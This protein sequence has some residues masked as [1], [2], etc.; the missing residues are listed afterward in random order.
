MSRKYFYTIVIAFFILLSSLVS[1]VVAYC[2][3]TDETDDLCFGAYK[4]CNCDTGKEQM[5]CTSAAQIR[6][7]NN[8]CSSSSGP[9]SCTYTAVGGYC[10][11]IS[12]SCSCAPSCNDCTPPACPAGSAETP[13]T[14]DAYKFTTTCSRGSGC[15]PANNTRTCYWQRQNLCSSATGTPTYLKPGQSSTVTST[16]N[17]SVNTFFY[18]FYNRDNPSLT[19]IVCSAT[20]IAG[21]ATTQGNCAPGTYQLMR[22]NTYTTARTSETISFP[23]NSIFVNDTNYG[24]TLAKNLQ[25]NAYYIIDG[26]PISFPNISCV[27]NQILCSPLCTPASCAPAY[28]T[29]NQGYGSTVFSC[30]NPQSECG[31][32]SRTCFCRACTPP[33]CEPQFSSVNYGY[34][35]TVLS[36][37][38]N[39]G[40]SGS[41]TCYIDRCNNCTLPDCPSPLTPVPTTTNPNMEL[42]VFRQCTKNPPCGGSSRV[43]SCFEQVSPQP[44]T[45]LQVFPDTTNSY[46]F[47]SNN[48][49]GIRMPNYNLNDPLHMT[50]TYTDVNGASDIEAVS[51][52]FRDSTQTGE[53]ASPLWIDSTEPP[54]AQSSSSWGFMMRY[55]G[56]SWV[57]Y[58]PSYPAIG[59][60]YWVRAVSSSGGFDIA[61]PG[62][63][64]MVRVTLGN[65]NL[66]GITRSGNNVV[67]PFQ[68]S[69]T[70]TG[71]SESV[72]QTN[73]NV[74]LMGND[75][76]SF[77]PNDNYTSSPE[78]NSKIGTYWQPG[79]LR[80]RTSPTPAQTYARQWVQRGT[81]TIDKQNP[82]SNPLSV[83]IVDD[84]VLELAWN[85]TDDKGIYA[86]VGN[87]YA[88][89]SMTSPSP[90]NIS[91]VT[92][93][94]LDVAGTYPLEQPP[95]TGIGHLN[96]NYAFRKLS[97]GSNTYSDRVRID[98]GN[99]NGGSLIIYLTVFDMA[100]N[101]TSPTLT[102]SLGDWI[103][104]YGGFTYSSGGMDYEIK[105]IEGDPW[106]A[107]D[108]LTNLDPSYADVTTELF[109]DRVASVAPSAL[110]KS[111]LV[112]SYHVRPFVANGDISNWYVELIKAYRGRL[113]ADKVDMLSISSITGNLTSSGG[114][115]TSASVCISQ[116]DNFTVGSPTQPFTCNTKGVFF[117]NG[118]LTIENEI[119]N[120]NINSDACI[121]V[122][123]GNVQINEG[124]Q[125]SSTTQIQYDRINAYIIANGTLTIAPELGDRK[126]D[127][128]FI[129]GGFYANGGLNMNRSLKLVDRNIYPAL[130]TSYHSKYAILSNLVFGSQIDMVKTEVGY[131]PY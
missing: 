46:G 107:V 37:T 96:N 82:E 119:L 61:G 2:A 54:R 80:Y 103:V 126:Y 86:V 52:W 111:S 3:V 42:S 81:W 59:T 113:I 1:T 29:V 84:T 93:G 44:T 117:V 26:R 13:S 36:C 121:F 28:E 57:P 120:S 41:R 97:V 70:Y 25:V 21:W 90:I 55:E 9:W 79:Q 109:G 66:A 50:A 110:S 58:I 108:V 15:D 18:A 27:F 100:G 125:R 67:L 30:S 105:N 51:V 102:Y 92:G 124:A 89:M 69:F 91:N 98:I 63:V 16:A 47:L 12:I 65:R 83:T 88:S 11:D 39:C 7:T 129:G 60:P 71:G 38:N 17:T 45:S 118:D 5:C 104:T 32:E 19:N 131:K 94:T 128:I 43:G 75:V 101:I 87:I 116:S 10:Y 20:P 99:N 122:V 72:A 130:V 24:G 77:T 56:S 85:I 8:N 34:G 53:V 4:D 14:G 114:C 73:Y 78:I 106:N 76:F 35:S 49:T 22:T 40:V 95:S 115:N 74:Y 64:R 6:C 112:G 33:T 123:N 31:T 127:G 23:A 48:Q 62:G 68:L